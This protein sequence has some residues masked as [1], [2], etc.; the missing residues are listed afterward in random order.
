MNKVF[1]TSMQI[2][3]FTKP[4][5]MKF[6]L[7]VVW[8]FLN[9]NNKLRWDEFDPKTSHTTEMGWRKSQENA[10]THGAVRRPAQV[11]EEGITATGTSVH[12]SGKI[13]HRH[14]Q[15]RSH[16]EVTPLPSRSLHIL[17]IVQIELK[18]Q[19]AASLWGQAVTIRISCLLPG[20]S[21]IEDTYKISLFSR[22]WWSWTRQGEDFSL[23]E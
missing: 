6:C 13:G 8:Y 7:Y 4:I 1:G 12:L 3:C 9:E 19:K 16:Q 21:K 20:I 18:A 11:K 23:I 2:Y 10:T 14:P 5:R 15:F 22:W 17:S